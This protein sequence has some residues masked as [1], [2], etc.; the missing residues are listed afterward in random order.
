MK[1][2]IIDLSRFKPSAQFYTREYIPGTPVKY[3]RT[4]GFSMITRGGITKTIPCPTWIKRKLP[5]I[6][7][8]G[9]L[10]DASFTRM[11]TLDFKHLHLTVY[12]TTQKGVLFPNRYKK[13]M[14]IKTN[15]Y[16]Q[17][18]PYSIKS[19]RELRT[20]CASKTLRLYSLKSKHEYTFVNEVLR[21]AEIIGLDTDFQELSQF[22]CKTP[23]GKIFYCSKGLSEIKDK[24]RFCEGECVERDANVPGVGDMILYTSKIMLKNGTLPR[25]AYFKKISHSRSCEQKDN[26]A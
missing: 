17:R 13:L 18:V 12:D 19:V 7:C 6:E 4:K 15:G 22:K 14:T 24:Y 26:N 9:V 2:P 8:K 1:K 21:E 20:L 10:S 25:D 23:E 11:G 16:I 5:S 3:S